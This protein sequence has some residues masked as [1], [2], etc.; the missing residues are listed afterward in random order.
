MD[1]SFYIEFCRLYMITPGF[2]HPLFSEEERC[3]LPDASQS[4]VE[5]LCLSSEWGAEKQREEEWKMIYDIF[6]TQILDV[7]WQGAWE[8]GKCIFK[9][10]ISFYFIKTKENKKKFYFVIIIHF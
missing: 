1:M 5:Y 10:G 7:V 9:C 8:E 2:Y 4:L 3:I 6:L